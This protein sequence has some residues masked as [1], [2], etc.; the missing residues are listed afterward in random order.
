MSLSDEMS[1]SLMK[2]IYSINNISW[3]SS[4]NYTKCHLKLK[5]SLIVYFLIDTYMIK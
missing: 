5:V 3:C 1:L 4:E 2:C